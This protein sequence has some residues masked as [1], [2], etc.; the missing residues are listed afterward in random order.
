[1]GEQ[2]RKLS[3]LVDVHRVVR[4]ADVS[5]LDHPIPPVFALCRYPSDEHWPMAGVDEG[6]Q[7]YGEVSIDLDYLAMR[8]C[9]LVGV[10]VVDRFPLIPEDE[11]PVVKKLN[12]APG[13]HDCSPVGARGGSETNL[14]IP[15][16]SIIA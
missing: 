6:G 7:L 13:R 5:Y 10:L 15:Y 2:P 1:M 3:D 16:S 11:G 9:A 8:H 4:L 14:G 12:E